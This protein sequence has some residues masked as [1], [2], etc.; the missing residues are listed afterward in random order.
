MVVCHFPKTGQNQSFICQ[1]LWFENRHACV[2][3]FGFQSLDSLASSDKTNAYKSVS[4][5]GSFILSLHHFLFPGVL[6]GLPV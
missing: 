6:D 1:W 4:P 5:L 3:G 2:Q